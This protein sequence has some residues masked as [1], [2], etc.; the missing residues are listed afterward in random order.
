MLVKSPQH[1]QYLPQNPSFHHAG[2]FWNNFS[3][4]H[5]AFPLPHRLMLRE[6]LPGCSPASNTQRRGSCQGTG[7]YSPQTALTRTYRIAKKTL[8]GKS[9]IN[10]EILLIHHIFHR[11]LW[12]HLTGLP[13]SIH[14]TQPLTRPDRGQHHCCITGA[15]DSRAGAELTAQTFPVRA[16]VSTSTPLLFP[17]T[18]FVW[19]VVQN[20]SWQ[21]WN[22]FRSQN[23]VALTVY[24]YSFKQGGVV[25]FGCLFCIGKQ[26]TV[27]QFT[28]LDLRAHGSTCH[29]L[30]W[31]NSILAVIH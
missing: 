30:T 19:V 6:G 10:A 23:E 9:V 5:M 16:P 20:T 4:A 24:H 12:E 29:I 21:G 18:I 17:G 28:L 31:M 1:T 25:L 3:A 7:L 13:S 2:V 15:E 22:T 8:L 27:S 26:T 11:Y 14:L